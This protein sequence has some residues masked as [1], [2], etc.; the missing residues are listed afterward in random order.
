[1]LDFYII[2]SYIFILAIINNTHTYV[3][4]ITYIYIVDNIN[5]CYK[6]I[7]TMCMHIICGINYDMI[8][9]YVLN[10]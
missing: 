7:Y 4:Y 5:T 9:Y 10:I 1:M 8:L 3:L 2:Y 6:H